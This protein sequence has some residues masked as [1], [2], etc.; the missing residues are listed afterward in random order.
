MEK[1]ELNRY[2]KQ[3]YRSLFLFALSLTKNKEDAEDLV[4]NAFLKA[5]LC[6]EEG[7]FKAW[8][9]TVIRNEFLNLYQGRKRFVKSKVPEQEG[10]EAWEWARTSE[11]ILQEYIKQEEKRWLYHQIYQLP[12]KERQIMILSS[13]HELSDE[14]TGKIMNL[15]VSNVR[16]IKHRVKKKLIE[17]YEKEEKRRK[18][19]E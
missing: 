6:F 19:Y 16:V 14:E 17:R 1:D 4:A 15:S 13:F 2:Y 9:Y 18:D 8:I 10:K 7:N 3:H 12:E 5:I 11:D